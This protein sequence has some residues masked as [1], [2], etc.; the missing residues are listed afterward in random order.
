MHF[1]TSFAL[2]DP[3]L[4]L[5]WREVEETVVLLLDDLQHLL[6]LPPRCPS[7]DLFFHNSTHR[8]LL[9]PRLHLS[10]F[11]FGHCIAV[12]GVIAALD[13]TKERDSA[14]I[15]HPQPAVTAGQRQMQRRRA[16]TPPFAGFVPRIAT[17]R[18][19]CCRSVIGTFRTIL[20]SLATTSD[21]SPT[22]PTPALSCHH[23]SSRTGV[24]GEGTDPA[25]SES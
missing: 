17:R 8:W 24:H 9:C 16:G 21:P 2:A 3:T 14:C 5:R 13:L 19:L 4:D 7:L 20:L 10:W 6:R 15:P 11:L 12:A 22:S 18:T 1:Q 25:W 23:S